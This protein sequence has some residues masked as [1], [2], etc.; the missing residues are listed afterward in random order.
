M[1]DLDS[2]LEKA[3]AESHVRS[4]SGAI[5]VALHCKLLEEGFECVAIG[6]EVSSRLL[7]VH[8]VTNLLVF[9]V[10]LWRRKD[11]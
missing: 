1:A 3:L 8:N 4:P 11:H 6:D 5:V 10:E 2:L 7:N 9:L